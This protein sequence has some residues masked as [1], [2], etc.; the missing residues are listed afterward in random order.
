MSELP[1]VSIL[2]V[3]LNGR[4]LLAD[5]LDSLAA[6]VYPADR[7]EIILLD[8]G[9]S[10]DSVP[11]VHQHHPAVKVV[12][13]GRNLGF[14]G[15]N[16]RAAR[17]A[18]GKFLALINNDATADPQ[19]LARM[20]EAAA[21][22][23]QIACVGARILNQTGELIDFD[24][25]AMNPYGR[26]FQIGEGLP[27]RSLPGDDGPREILAPCGGAMLIRR[28]LFEQLGG[29]DED[30]IAYYED[31]DLGWRS[32]LAGYRVVIEPRAVVYHKQHMTGSAF[33][34]EQRQALSELNALRMVIK[35]YD[36]ANFTRLLSLSL[37]MAVRR[38][39]DQ[40][41]LDREPYRLGHPTPDGLQDGAMQTEPGAA[42]VATSTLV[43]IDWLADELPQ[44][45][46]KRTLVQATRVRSDAEIFERFPLRSDN[47]VFPWREYTVTHDRLAQALALPDVLKPRHGSRLLILTHESIGERMA[48]PAIRAWEMACALGDRFDVTL[49]APGSPSRSHP[50]VRLV[51]YES[52]DPNL[53]S[54][55]P[56][57]RNADIVLAMGPLFGR[58]P[59][60]QDLGKPTIVDLYDP[61][62]LE[63]LAQSAV[64]GREQWQRL[65]AEGLTDL[66]LQSALGDF[67]ICASERQRDFWLGSLLAT[68]RVN[69][70]TSA[71][72]PTFR[73]LI[74]V[75]PFGI[76][77][78]LPQ[79]QRSVLKG[80]LPGI[81][82]TDKVLLW[83]GG[84]WQWFDPL[85]LVEAMA[86]IAHV[87]DDVK[88]YF[89]AGRHFDTKTAPEMP[90][91]RAV[92]D[93]CQS[94]GLLDRFVFFGDWIPYDERADYLLEADLGISVSQPGLESRF[95]S[96][97]RLLDCVW[98]GLPVLATGGDPVADLIVERGLG[99]A[100]TS[101]E[102]Q[103]LAQAIL[104]A[105]AED[106]L[107]E[108][109]RARAD[110]L[111]D[112]LSWRTCVEP[113]ASYLQH[114]MFAPDA[115][116]ATK[117]AR[118][119]GQVMRHIRE[120]DETIQR[121]ESVAR[122]LEL[123]NLDLQVA[124]QALADAQ[125]RW[126]HEEKVLLHEQ[127]AKDAQIAA[128]NDHLEAIKRGRFMR[129]MRATRIALGREP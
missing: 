97:T 9:S 28:E 62:E 91:C 101:S 87:R 129:L 124:K 18:S 55:Q 50:G 15:G 76:P 49:A 26:A 13:A 30:Y 19:W 114:A 64:L 58:M 98:T 73:S 120:L 68:G 115:L 127:Q 113:I 43:A 33:P 108:R 52:Q 60:L 82:A 5:C 63:K 77:D 32:W 4:L 70:Q 48:G 2:V 83:N 96:R 117:N 42:R 47:W 44:L 103:A 46:V 121:L 95:A 75:V 24:G 110:G 106:G 56:H 94:L 14:A 17:A 35:N 27:A 51:G 89:A 37:F 88:L 11:Y 71:Q 57:I 92:I 40:A 67:F 16:N 81:A 38:A 36:E 12:E 20:V 112:Q 105:L 53:N 99:Y 80:V 66:Q 3:N 104:S 10:D 59:G 34:V 22:D 90:I 125:T 123:Q 126:Q 31:V 39:L 109:V 79:A 111:R 93:R 100:L 72:D 8:N 61:Y 84:I 7:V 85:P 1:S 74:D 107:R 25:T 23:P 65:D 128:L 116:A 122:D 29:F 118:T 54:L 102:P 86:E 119:I 45:L 6:Q 41:R 21:A 69:M 78:R